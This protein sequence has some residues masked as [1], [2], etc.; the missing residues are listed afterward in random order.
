MRILRSLIVSQRYKGVK[1]GRG[2]RATSHGRKLQKIVKRGMG[3]AKS[4]HTGWSRALPQSA[5]PLAE[6]RDS[7]GSMKGLC[8]KVLQPLLAAL[9][10]VPGVAG[11]TVRGSLSGVVL[12]PSRA[13]VPG[14]E[15]RLTHQESGVVR[16]T[17]TSE[18]GEFL[19]PALP[20][21]NYRLEITRS[22]FQ[23]YTATLILLVH[24]NL[25]VSAELQLNEVREVVLDAT[26]PLLRATDSPAL[27]TVIENRKIVNLPLDGR[28]F[29]ELSLLVPGAVPAAQG[30]AGAVRGDFALNVNGAR[31]DANVFLLDGVY[32]GD[33][34]LN[35]VGVTP[36]VDGIREFEV[37]TSNYDASFG[38]N[39]GGQINA[40]LKAGSNLFHGTAYWFGRNAALDARNHFAPRNEPDPKYQ[41]NQF[42]FSLGGPIVRERTFFFGDY[43]GTILREGITRIAS[44]PTM[45]ERSGD[46]SQSLLPPP[47]DPFTQ[48]PF[49]GGQIPSFFQHP[50]G[51]AIAAL[52][53][54]PNRSTPGA[55][56][57][58]SPTLRDSRHQFDARVDHHL[59]S[60]SELAVR[61]SFVDRDLFEPFA[62][63]AFSPLPGFGNDVPRRAQNLLLSHTQLF[64]S[65]LV[66][67]ARF[68]FGRVSIGVFQENRG[69]SLNQQ[70]G[71]PDVSADPGDFGLS[72]L[73][74]SGFSALGHEYNS[75]QAS[76]SNTFQVIDQVS[77]ARGR[78]L[79]KFGGEF[80]AVRQD[81]FRN[82]QARGFLNF[83]GA[84]TGN[85]LA[86]LLLG[87]PTV[88]GAARL[89]NPQRLRTE[90]WS[91]FAQDTY[92]LAS[93]FTV[94]LGLRYEYNSPPVD[95]G[96]RANIY[97]PATQQLVRV[98]TGGV[99]RA[100]YRDDR[101]NFGPRVG[102]AW[103][104]GPRGSTLLRA[105]YGIYFDQT[106]L[107][108][109]EGLFFNAP[110]FDFRLFFSLPPQPPFFP[111]Y[112]LTLSDPFPSSFPVALPQS[113]LTYQ[114]DLRTPYV[115]HW[116]L[117]VQQRLGARRVFELAYAGA[118]GT[119]LLSARDINQP[120]ASP[121][122]PNPRP[123]PQFDDITQV[124]SRA[125]ST[126]HA[127]QARFQQSYD[128][129]LSLLAS[130]TWSKS[131]DDASGFFPTAGDANFPQDSRTLVG[132]RARSNFDAAQRLSLSFGYDFPYCREVGGR[133]TYTGWTSWIF[134]GWS[135]FGIVTLQEGRPFTVA[136]LP[137]VD[138]SNTG[139]S[140]L[141]F[142]ANDR[143]NVT[144]NP[145]AANPGEA[146]WFN[147]SAFVT[148]AFGSFGNAGRNILEGP[149]LAAVNTSLVKMIGVREGVRLQFRAE[150]FNLFNR[151][152]YDLPDSFVGSPTFG[153]LVSAQSPR[154]LQLGFKLLF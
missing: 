1:Q 2:L 74:I 136:L 83:L 131:I 103:A 37:L 46:F 139:R 60:G 67:E 30:S 109:G 128:F 99:P 14:A 92:R 42:G 55:N 98:G 72:F 19:F 90:S 75:P 16:T 84:F 38:R 151:T 141:G 44:V 13:V 68:A 102:L 66:N 11:Q 124:E 101:N 142:G 108:P 33:P 49:P 147:T 50:V 146:R 31:D 28:N 134:G 107:A 138:N 122:T 100:G 123:V 80:R 65:S 56:F 76:T 22:G 39:A 5:A 3:R 62:G 18:L 51:Q 104:L 113:A 111:G 7:G 94:T 40:I 135:T 88:T 78:H 126:Y 27:G 77:Y 69:T 57:V 145:D 9:L 106:P 130:Y 148:P 58:S 137:E 48:M 25:R 129:G 117:S 32:N 105:G 133:V 144:G 12:D 118:K 26:D 36:P 21:G 10:F 116:N 6:T 119:H 71:L 85:P 17:T 121:I 47:V 150:A 45:A 41:R 152:N 89:D 95:A 59:A 125:S 70:V 149:G 140:I 96:D 97:D 52:Y 114:R 34:K 23:K 43:E 73:R 15:A 29:A 143:P 81:A 8:R 53:P 64:S 112:T 63:P 115:Q 91:F 61:Y 86:D 87:L 127:L 79:F 24:Q 35:G 154:R 120:G 153:Q 132:E 4:R 54:L 110:F 82:V 93:N 20:A